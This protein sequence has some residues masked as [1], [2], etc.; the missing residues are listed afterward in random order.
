MLCLGFCTVAVGFKEYFELIKYNPDNLDFFLLLNNCP[1]TF[2]I[3]NLE[4]SLCLKKDY[5]IIYLCVSVYVLH[6]IHAGASAV[7]K[8]VELEF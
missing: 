5:F 6:H 7:S 3:K 4:Q 8:R 1:R 2:M